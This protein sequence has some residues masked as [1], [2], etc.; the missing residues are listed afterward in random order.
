MRYTDPISSEITKQV[1]T[2]STWGIVI[3]IVLVVLGII[4]IARPLY[5]TIASTWVFGWLFIAAG[6]AQAVFAL[7]SPGI[8]Q[9]IWKLMLGIFYLVAGIYVV[10]N[11]I[12][13][14]M[15]LTLVLGITIFAQGVIQVILAFQMRPDPS[16]VIG[17]IA[18][19]VGIILGIFIWSRFPYSAD[20]LIGLWVGLHFLMTGAW[21]LVVSSVLRAA[22]R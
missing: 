6:V 10:S 9:L 19:I 2:G 17:L 12:S 18:G 16:W 14:A 11:P 5:A 1:R 13:G 22:V 20:W 21:V 7:R 15:A 8:G 4:A 3:G